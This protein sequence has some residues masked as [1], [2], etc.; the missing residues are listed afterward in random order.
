MANYLT[1]ILQLQVEY[2]IP[3]QMDINE[4]KKI[5]YYKKYYDDTK[6]ELCKI[7]DEVIKDLEEKVSKTDSKI[8][9]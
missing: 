5:E 6:P 7:L 8:G 1:K 3:I 2:H 9:W 4:K